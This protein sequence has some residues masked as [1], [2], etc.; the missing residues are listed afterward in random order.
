M[1][2]RKG[3]N[4]K[5]KYFAYFFTRLCFSLL[6]TLYLA[7]RYLLLQTYDLKEI[8]KKVKP[9]ERI[10]IHDLTQS[11]FIIRFMEL[12]Y[13]LASIKQKK[14]QLEYAIALA[15]YDAKCALKIVTSIL[16]QGMEIELKPLSFYAVAAIHKNSTLCDKTNVLQIGRET[17][18]AL[19]FDERNFD[20]FLRIFEATLGLDNALSLTIL[21][22]IEAYYI[23][24]LTS[25]VTHYLQSIA[26][27][28]KRLQP[29]KESMNQEAV[30]ILSKVLDLDFSILEGGDAFAAETLAI[31]AKSLILL[32]MEKALL[33]LELAQK[34]IKD[35]TNTANSLILIAEAYAEF[36]QDEAFLIAQQAHD[37]IKESLDWNKEMELEVDKFEIK[38]PCV[39]DYLNR[40]IKIMASCDQKYAIKVLFESLDQVHTSNGITDGKYYSFG[41]DH[42][43]GKLFMG[44]L[45]VITL[46]DREL[47]FKM[48]KQC[49]EWVKTVETPESHLF[50]L[51]NALAKDFPQEALEIAHLLNNSNLHCKVLMSVVRERIDSKNAKSYV[52]RTSN[53]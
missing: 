11:P 20:D 32:D 47:A 1:Q 40:I 37:T 28:I 30:R 39:F 29:L 7:I 53:L 17:H 50:D 25:H 45:E 5:I 35:S 16:N 8:F 21:I 27:T 23:S 15:N 46:L 2:R 18:Y 12:G 19:L 43:F 49:V 4:R 33:A 52:E 22:E 34:A 44:T 42:I 31:V 51:S 36:D 26:K 14:Q 13:K 41:F 3:T 24:P 38:E 48:V 9:Y 6:Y 10:K